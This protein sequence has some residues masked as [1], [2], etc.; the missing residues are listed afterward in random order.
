VII[1]SIVLFLRRDCAGGA[2][3]AIEAPRFGAPVPPVC[4]VGLAASVV[5]VA[6]A[7][8]GVAVVPV[9]A[10]VDVVAAVFEAGCWPSENILG[11]PAEA[12][13]AAVDV[14]AVCALPV[15]VAAGAPIWNAETPLA[16][17]VE[18]GVVEEA[19]PPNPGNTGFCGVAVD[20]AVVEGCDV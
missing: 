4:A 13:A 17:G 9:A 11:A 16:A 3:P 20:G 12:G 18:D 7:V 2:G 6:C 10:V 5:V 15:V 8:A 19:A 1:S 14:D